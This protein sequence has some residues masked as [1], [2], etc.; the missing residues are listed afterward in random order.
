IDIVAGGA[1]P[2]RITLQCGQLIV[3]NQGA[4][5]EQTPDQGR[6]A[7]IDRSAGQKAQQILV[8]PRRELSV[9]RHQKYPCGSF[10]S[11]RLSWS[12]R[13]NRPGVPAAPGPPIPRTILGGVAAAVPL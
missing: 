9:S 1:E 10:A 3:Q 7:V 4:I 13:F 11:L 2:P 8:A 12:C 5:V 6:F